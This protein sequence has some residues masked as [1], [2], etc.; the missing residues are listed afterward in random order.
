MFNTVG[1]E[2]TRQTILQ[3]WKK[4]AEGAP[5]E[6]FEMVLCEVIKQHPEYHTFL[7]QGIQA[8]VDTPDNP[9]LHISMHLAV[10]EQCTTDRPPGIQALYAQFCT[11]T[12][13]EHEAQHA[14]ISVLSDYLFGCFSSNTLPNDTEY[15]ARLSQLV[16]K[17]EFAD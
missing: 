16:L 15:W 6:P 8:S 4:H 9:F 13:S 2:Q 17:P 10:L 11:K 1:L 3:A 12:G 5:L 7:K 14:I